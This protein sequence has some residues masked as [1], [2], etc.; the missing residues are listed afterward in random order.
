MN[1]FVFQNTTKFYSEP[2]STL[3]ELGIDD[4]NFSVMAQKACA[5]GTLQGFKPFTPKDVEAICRM[6]L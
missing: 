5:G 4:A 6:C 1:E 2:K 3:T